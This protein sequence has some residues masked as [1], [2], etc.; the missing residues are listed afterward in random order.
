MFKLVLPFHRAVIIVKLEGVEI[1][2]S[3]SK[4]QEY[5]LFKQNSSKFFTENFLQRDIEVRLSY[6]DDE[7][8][9]FIGTICLNKRNIVEDLLA[10]GLVY[11]SDPELLSEYI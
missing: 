3:T 8:K 9:A 7:E 6:F 11:I 10:E 2:N 1:L 4:K 5:L